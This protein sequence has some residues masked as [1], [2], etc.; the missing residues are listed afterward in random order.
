MYEQ[1][2]LLVSGVPDCICF[3]YNLLNML[4]GTGWMLKL[5]II[6]TYGI[7]MYKQ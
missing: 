2:L 1:D 7:F 3:S 4:C 6:N 5:K